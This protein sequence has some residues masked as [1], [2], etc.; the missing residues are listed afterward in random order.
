[1]TYKEYKRARKRLNKITDE[2]KKCGYFMCNGRCYGKT[3]SI[4]REY[5]NLLNKVASY[6]LSILIK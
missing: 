3:P 2:L 5:Y 4:F 6:E 1:M